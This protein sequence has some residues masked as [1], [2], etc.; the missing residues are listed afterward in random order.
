MCG[1]VAAGLLTVVTIAGSC[2]RYLNRHV[3]RAR[4]RCG[5]SEI[6][7]IETWHFGFGCTLTIPSPVI[8]VVPTVTVISVL[9][10]NRTPVTL[11]SIIVGTGVPPGSVVVTLNGS[12]VRAR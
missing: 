2:K 11:S 6:D 7:D 3:S 8:A 9:V 1:A 5:E 10:A 4:K 12:S